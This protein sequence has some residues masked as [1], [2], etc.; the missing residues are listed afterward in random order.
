MK[1]VNELIASRTKAAVRENERL[2]QVI[3]Q[4]VPA[5]AIPHIQFCRVDQAILKVTL[6][7]ASW[8]ARLRFCQSQIVDEISRQV[9]PIKEVT[10][11]I[12]PAE[13]EP[14]C[15]TSKRP[16]MA[17]SKASAHTVRRT[18]AALEDGRLRK[19]LLS[20]ADKLDS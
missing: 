10:W 5:A 13:I 1:S 6:N 3:S 14:T 2:T 11:H 4:I 19:A 9:R 15:R 16:R 17:S 8:V 12:L 7:N 20:V 18:A